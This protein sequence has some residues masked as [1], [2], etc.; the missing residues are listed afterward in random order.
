M[1]TAETAVASGLP[2]QWQRWF[3][4]RLAALHTHS[5]LRRLRPIDLIRAP[6]PLPPA[7]V[8]PG[9]VPSSGK[10]A[11][12][13]A[14]P[15]EWGVGARDGGNVE[16]AQAG[17]G[18]DEDLIEAPWWDVAAVEA[19][20][21]QGMGPR[22]S[23]LVTGFTTE[24]E[25]LEHDI[26]RLKGTQA[27][28]LCPTGF[29]ANLAVLAS[30]APVPRSKS[31]DRSN[32]RNGSDSNDRRG[33]G[34]IAAGSE[35]A[36]RSE[37]SS[38][39]SGSFRGSGGD[40]SVGHGQRRTERVEEGR[41][42]SL[43]SIG[44]SDSLAVFSDELN[45][46]SIIDALRLLLPRSE[47]GSAGEGR[48]GGGAVAAVA[49]HVY[50]HNDMTHLDQLL[51]ASSAT[52]KLV[53]TDSLFSMDGDFAPLPAL[54]ALKAKHGF[55][56]VLDEAHATLVCGSTGGGAAEEMGVKPAV[57]VHVGTLSKAVGCLGGYIACS[58]PL[59]DFFA[60]R[61]RSFIFSTALPVPV[62]AAARAALAVAAEERWRQRA[63][64]RRVKQ[65]GEGLGVTFTSPICPIVLGSADLALQASRHL[66]L[67]GFHVPAIRPP[68]VAPGS[69]RLRVALSA[70]HTPAH[71]NALI[72]ALRPILAL[73][74]SH[75]HTTLLHAV[76]TALPS[77][78]PSPPPPSSSPLLLQTQCKQQQQL[79]EGQEWWGG[80]QRHGWDH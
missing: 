38:S 1:A 9:A 13:F 7:L 35:C 47:R 66:L 64:W 28:L 75:S 43:S 60:S 46:A 19:A 34:A 6:V 77:P 54:A 78:S 16:R 76:P 14:R 4:S 62:V 3:D 74:R 67:S 25:G 48:A 61:G 8:S 42:D 24:H 52:R 18:A 45:H 68:T 39:S 69:S 58:A 12:D 70:S 51:T 2:P 27:C 79:R 50:R 40:R 49:L 65:L 72:T 41:V 20:W 31:K 10:S 11:E 53:V 33:N 73:S 30:L 5:L 32:S 44:E 59:R 21:Q 29:A 23:A 15:R 56:L 63:V 37:N 26:A 80:Q 55:L 22:A 57:D 71:V 36:S 17:E